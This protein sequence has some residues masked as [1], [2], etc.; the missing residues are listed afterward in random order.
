[1]QPSLRMIL[2]WVVGTIT[3]GLAPGASAQRARNS[4]G[5]WIEPGFVRCVPL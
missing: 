3:F 1:M 4:T 5:Q 2:I